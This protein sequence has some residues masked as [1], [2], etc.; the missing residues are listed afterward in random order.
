[1]GQ[2]IQDE[3]AKENEQEQNKIKCAD[4]HRKMGSND[5]DPDCSNMS[6]M[7]ASII[8]SCAPPSFKWHKQ[9]QNDENALS[10]MDTLS[11]SV[12]AAA[13]GISNFCILPSAD[14]RILGDSKIWMK[15]LEDNQNSSALAQIICHFAWKNADYSRK[16]IRHFVGYL[17]DYNDNVYNSAFV[18]LRRLF[19]MNDYREEMDSDDDDDD[20]D[21]DESMNRS[22]RHRLQIRVYANT[23]IEKFLTPIIK[24]LREWYRD[25]KYPQSVA[26]I[27]QFIDECAQ[28]NG[29]VAAYFRIKSKDA[30]VCWFQQ[31]LNSHS[32]YLSL[33]KPPE[34]R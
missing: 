21:D 6:A 11:D 28:T 33:P 2:L 16:T 26:K 4:R 3:D 25:N 31:F 1:M 20:Y 15:F 22:R 23:R 7:L 17:E 18:C 30:N 12:S 34:M 24:M 14:K 32:Y 27:A 9:Q 10:G 29:A 5:A 19:L 8:C 13:F